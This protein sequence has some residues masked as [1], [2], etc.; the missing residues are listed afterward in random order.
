MD[1]DIKYMRE[2]LKEAKKAYKINEIQVGC[3]FVLNDKIRA[4][5]YNKRE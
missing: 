4:R 3:F 5:V 1:A 2:A